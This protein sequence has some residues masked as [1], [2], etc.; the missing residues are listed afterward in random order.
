MA[1]ERSTASEYLICTSATRPSNQLVGTLIYETDTSRTLTFNGSTWIQQLPIM[2][3]SQ[4]DEGASATYSAQFNG[5]TTT[6]IKKDASNNLQL[7]FT[8]QVDAWWEVSVH[9]GILQKVD[10]AYHYVYCVLEL[11][12]APAVGNSVRYSIMTE[13][14]SVNNYMS[15]NKTTL[16]KLN[17]GTTY[18][19]KAFF[20]GGSGGTW[21]YYQGSDRLHIHGK[22]WNQ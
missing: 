15:F 4:F 20:G 13:H 6:Y 9:V 3:D 19:A 14:A 1:I 10:A 22:A 21:Q 2:K 17:A 11:A 8:P 18:T 16:F 12:P 7:V 5:T